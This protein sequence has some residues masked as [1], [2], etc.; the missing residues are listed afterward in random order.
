[1]A[2]PGRLNRI[3]TGELEELGQYKKHA[4]AELIQIRRTKLPQDGTS[5]ISEGSLSNT[6]SCTESLRPK[7]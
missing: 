7:L 5:G 2:G 1:M 3:E 6:E 4:D